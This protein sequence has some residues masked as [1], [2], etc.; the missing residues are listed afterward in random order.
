MQKLILAEKDGKGEGG[1]VPGLIT[2]VGI[3]GRFPSKT[4]KVSLISE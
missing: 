2:K 3:S 1:H 4:K